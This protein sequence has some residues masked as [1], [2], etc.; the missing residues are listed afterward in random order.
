MLRCKPLV[1]NVRSVG[2][3]LGTLP[4]LLQWQALYLANA[5]SLVIIIGRN[6]ADRPDKQVPRGIEAAFFQFAIPGDDRHI[7]AI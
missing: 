6:A 3:I 2:P 7:T 5:N 1:A 4:S